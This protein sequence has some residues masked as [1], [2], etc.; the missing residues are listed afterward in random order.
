MLVGVLP[1]VLFPSSLQIETQI[2]T[3]LRESAAV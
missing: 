2:E 3:S 1:P